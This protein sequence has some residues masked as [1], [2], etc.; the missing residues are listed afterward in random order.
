MPAA[1]EKTRRTQDERSAE[2]QRRLIEATIAII[3]E[4]GYANLTTPEIAARAGVSRGALQHHFRTR[5]DLLVAVSDRLTGTML[6]LGE[7]IK[8][9]GL[10]LNARVRAVVRHYWSVYASPTFL[11]VLNIYLGVQDDAP[12]RRRIRRHFANV[13]RA[14]DRPWLELFADTAMPRTRLVALRRLALAT[15]RGLAVARHLGILR[16]APEAELALLCELLVDQL[17]RTRES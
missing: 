17:R 1:K 8:V 13:Y 2:T 12:M 11:A 7:D 3:C 14:S 16:H 6:A 9:R 5:Y 4:R 15:L 10:S